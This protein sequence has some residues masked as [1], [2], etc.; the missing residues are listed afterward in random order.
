MC[1]CHVVFFLCVFVLIGFVLQ[2]KLLE[3]KIAGMSFYSKEQS[4]S[5]RHCDKSQV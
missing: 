3:P 2:C 4:L 5:A 1:R